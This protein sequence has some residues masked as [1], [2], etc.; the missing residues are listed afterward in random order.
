MP[1]APSTAPTNG[2][3]AQAKLFLPNGVAVDTKG[4]VY[5]ADT[6]NSAIRMIDT[7]GKITTLAGNGKPGFSGDKGAAL[8]AQFAF[9]RSVSVD[10]AG[11]IQIADTG[12]Q[13][14]RQLKFLVTPPDL[15][16]TTDAASKS[17]NDG[18]TVPVQLALTSMGGFAGTASLSASGPGGVGFQFTP[19]GTLSWRWVRA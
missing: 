7:T 1:V 10:S 6:L 14:I 4:N 13:R 18:S 2:P 15:T 11:N 19:S 3:A 17:A 5:I 12:N 16:I 8:N 9:P